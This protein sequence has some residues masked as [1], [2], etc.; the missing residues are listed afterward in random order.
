MSMEWSEITE[1]SLLERVDE[2]LQARDTPTDGCTVRMSGDDA[3]SATPVKSFAPSYVSFWY[4]SGAI[5]NGAGAS[6]S[7]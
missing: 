6:I 2:H 4:M 5:T 7:V 3:S 1:K